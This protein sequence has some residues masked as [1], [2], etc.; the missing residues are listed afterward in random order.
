M[1]QATPTPV[2]PIRRLPH[3]VKRVGVSGATI[4]RMR[5]RGEFPEPLHLS[6]GCVGWLDS[7]IVKWL[8]TRAKAGR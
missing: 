2:D 1:M 6:P 3:V 4:W 5:R 7:D 8:A